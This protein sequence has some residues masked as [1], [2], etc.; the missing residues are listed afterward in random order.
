VSLSVEID[1]TAAS[2]ILASMSH[3]GCVAVRVVLALLLLM[4]MP[5]SLYGKEQRR[6]SPEAC[7]NTQGG[8]DVPQRAFTE[9]SCQ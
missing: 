3:R 1:S 4:M 9:D 5:M 2:M 7:Q 8:S 6:S